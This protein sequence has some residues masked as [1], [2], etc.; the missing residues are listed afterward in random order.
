MN[1][2]P[3]IFI[4]Y[5]H[6]DTEAKKKLIKQLA[7]MKQNKEIEVWDDNEMLAGDRWK[8]TISNKL[9]DSDILLYLVSASSLAS[10]NCNKELGEAVAHKD[11]RVIPVILEYCD[12]KDHQLSGF[13][14]L[15][16][17]GKPINEWKPEANGWQNVVAE[18]RKMIQ[19][20]T[21]AILALSKGNFLSRFKLPNYAIKSFSEV[22]ELE[23]DNVRAYANRGVTYV[24]NDDD[25]C[26]IEDFN[27]AIRKIIRE[28]TD[29]SVDGDYIYRGE[30][31]KYD[32]VSSNLYRQYEKIIRTKDFDIK[33]VQKEILK[34]ANQYSDETDPFIIQAE[35]QHY[36]GKTNL[37]D[38]TA[39]YLVALFFACDGSRDEDGRVILQKQDSIKEQLKN[40]KI[41]KHRVIAQKSIF[42]EPPEGYI[43]PDKTVAIPKGLKQPMLNYL[44]KH[45]DI[46]TSTIYNDLHGFIRKR[47]AHQSAYTEFY[48]G[49]TLSDQGNYDEAIEHYNKSIRLNPDNA[50]S[51][52]NRGNACRNK[53][54]YDR[55]M[56]DYDKA[57]ELD[58]NLAIA[59]HNRGNVYIQQ[60]GSDFTKS[61]RSDYN[62]AIELDPGSTISYYARAITWLISSDWENAKTDLITAQRLGVDI[63]S[64]FQRNCGSIQQFEKQFGIT[65]PS[66]IRKLLEPSKPDKKNP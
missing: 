47:E 14:T 60:G 23:P 7:V 18:L 45:H 62:K 44:R 56:E 2:P 53:G 49:V 61:A 58:S 9:V 37:I 8:E 27:S 51:Y 65:L 54:D 20:D 41:P 10:E 36:G 63:V 24:N 29:E 19:E 40:P 3:K 50:S 43:K 12:W 42:V 15:P 57:I 32:E 26:A 48:K 30:P 66:D 21:K 11:I 4:T 1:K 17:K 64:D 22:I 13:E 16:K 35:L 38:F 5:A 31:E 6:D 39:D 34:E 46:S 59:Y 25:N 33:V 28:I 52:Y 55:A